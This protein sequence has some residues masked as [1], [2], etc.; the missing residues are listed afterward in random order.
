MPRGRVLL[1]LLLVNMTLSG[2]GIFGGGKKTIVQIT[3]KITSLPAGQVYQF[4]ANVQHDQ[5]KGVTVSLNGAGTLVLDTSTQSAFYIAPPAP[6]NPNSVT[7]TVTAGNGSGVS[8]S[9]TFTIT[10][11]AGPVVSITPATP[12]VSA[13]SGTPVTLNLA[14]TMDSAGDILTPSVAASSV[15]NGGVCGSFGA[16]MG[17]A[18]SGAYTV[19]YFPPSSVSA[20]TLQQISVNSSLASS[21][22]GTAFVTINP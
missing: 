14:V 3:N 21:T 19:Q 16:V 6:P 9:D 8:D 4:M 5:Q 17:T 18:G 15:C 2:C 20:S 13:S 12:T 1:T 10:P 7:V 11:A 22:N